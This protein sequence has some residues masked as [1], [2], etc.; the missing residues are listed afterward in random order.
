MKIFLYRILKIYFIASIVFLFSEALYSQGYLKTS[1][2]KIINGS[3]QEIILRGIGLG[4]WMLQEGYML[5]TSSFANTQHDIRKKIED[6]IGKENTD[7]FYNAWLANDMRRDDIDLAAGSGFNSIRIPMHYNLFTLPIE[8]E[9]VEGLNTWLDKGFNIVDSLLSWCTANKIYLILDLHT[10][11]GGQGRDAAISDYDN[12]KPSLWES[13]QNKSKTVALWKKLAERYHNEEWIGGY[14]LINETNWNFEGSNLNGCDE[15]NNAPLRSLLVD[16]TNAI[17]EADTNHIIFIEGNCWANN[18]NGLTPPWDN[19]MAYSFHKYWNEN[20]QS[21]I[22]WILN[23]RDTY[24]VPVW[25]GESGENSNQWFTDAI[26][27]LEQNKIGWSWWPW[28]KFNSLS[29]ITSVSTTAGYKTLLNYWS[30]GGTKPS[31]SYAKGALMEMTEKIKLENC[32]INKGVIDAMFRQVS[33]NETLPYADNNIPGAVYAADYD[34]GQNGFAYKDED[35]QNTSGPGQATWNSGSGYRNDGVDIETCSDIFSNGYNVGWINSGEFLRYTIN[36]QQTGTYDIEIRIS[37]NQ[38]GGKILLRLDGNN[39][40]TILDVP[41]TGG[42]QNW[43]SIFAR[44]VSIIQGS[45]DFEA[46]FFFEGFNLNLFDF[47]LTSSGINREQG[48]PLKYELLQNFPNPFNPST[49]IK[50]SIIKNQYVSLKIY[51]SIGKEI[52]ELINKDLSA[53]TYSVEWNAK[54]FASGVYYYSIITENYT[55][56]KKMILLK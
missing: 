44:N 54:N 10:A 56:Y 52:A 50:F 17:R 34:Y 43:E 38:S 21:S 48:V 31:E 16:I 42:W 13:D 28:K 40:G 12:S 8:E 9:P 14:D 19:N 33:T 5:Q 23:I 47:S 11:P 41:A 55:D 46:T 49:K 3:G 27:L 18:F 35:Y 20:N 36:A 26:K 51:N 32:S 30:N 4:G 7:T 15:S 53:G 24:N 37:G 45:H 2:K 1:G 29:G 22:Q 25:L 6:L 39:I